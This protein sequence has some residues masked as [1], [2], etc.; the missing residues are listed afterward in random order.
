MKIPTPHSDQ[1]IFVANN[2]FNTQPLRSD[3]SMDRNKKIVNV[4]LKRPVPQGARTFG[5]PLSD[6]VSRAP[7]GYRVPFIV[8]KICSHIQ[9]HGINEEGIFRLSGS[10]ATMERLRAQFDLRGDAS[11]EECG[12]IMAIAGMLKV[13]LR[14]MPEATIP[15]R[16]TAQFLAIHERFPKDPKSCVTHLKPLLK[17]LPDEHYDLLKHVIRFLAIVACNEQVN[18]MSPMAL[19]IVFGPNLFMSGKGFMALKDQGTMNQIIYRFIVD[20]NAL[21]KEADEDPPSVYWER[22]K[23]NKVPDRPPPPKLSITEPEVSSPKPTPLPRKTKLKS[24]EGNQVPDIEEPD[25]SESSISSKGR[26]S[27]SHNSFSFSDEEMTGRLSPFHL[28]SESGY[29]LVESPVPSARTSEFV[30]KAIKA[31]VIGHLFGDDTSL[32]NASIDTTIQEDPLKAD[33]GHIDPNPDLQLTPTNVPSS[34]KSRVQAFE[35]NQLDVPSQTSKVLK[36]K[37]SSKPS[38]LFEGKGPVVSQ[39]PVAASTGISDSREK[40]KEQFEAV[41]RTSDPLQNFKRSAGP[42]NRRTPSRTLR[43]NSFSDTDEEVMDAQEDGVE[44]ISNGHASDHG[45]LD[46]RMDSDTGLLEKPSRIAF[47]DIRH[48]N[49]NINDRSPTMNAKPFVPPLD[50]STLHENVGGQDPILAHKAQAATYQRAAMLVVPETQNDKEDHEN[51]EPSPH[52]NKV[53]RKAGHGSTDDE[54][55]S[56]MKGQ[57]RRIQGL[58]KKIRQFEDVFEKEHGFKPSH[59]EKASKPEIKKFMAELSRARKEAK[60]L[61]EEAEMGSR[62]RHGSGASSTGERIEPPDLPPSMGQTLDMILKRLHEKRKDFHR[63]E[64]IELMNHEQVQEEKLAVQKALLHFEGIHGRPKSRDE[65]DLMRPLYD[66]YRTIKRL[67]SRQPMSPRGNLELQPVP[68]DRPIDINSKYTDR[69]LDEKSP[70]HVPTA[71]MDNDDEDEE[72]AHG[73]GTMDFAVTRDLSSILK[74]RPTAVENQGPHSPK[75]RRKLE[76]QENSKNSNNQYSDSN[77]H[78]LSVP[79][80][81]DELIKSRNTKKH[82]RKKLRDFEEGFTRQTGRKVGR[83]DRMPMQTEYNE[84]KQLKARLKLLEALMSKHQHSEV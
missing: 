1:P 2:L 29:S 3:A 44:L 13:F 10:H 23:N 16:M 47:L 12:D 73:F 36:P 22:K 49:T 28:D 76:M 19:A 34:V 55:T 35:N 79:Q 57:M 33:E 40:G 43:R 75:A 74:T 58:K 80:L 20:Y 32:L 82:L 67:L 61:K 31:T 71:A 24:F 77:L 17:E 14:E 70:I 51:D 37:T 52:S 54:L 68:E 9:H 18:K 11:L 46:P 41:N 48:D 8:K 30:D 60:R 65:K 39:L 72:A 42:Q 56:K 6:L 45:H 63:P 64:D 83:E 78:E 4:G 27:H 21:F 69:F 84:Y 59:A 62:S 38:E 25:H 15:D 7:K 66:R 50:F 81:Q 53:K 5:V 26:N